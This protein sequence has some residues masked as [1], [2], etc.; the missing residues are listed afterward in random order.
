MRRQRELNP[1]HSPL[2]ELYWRRSRILNIWGVRSAVGNSDAPSL[3]MNLAK[4]RKRFAR[5]SSL[6]A[7]KGVD[8]AIGG[9]IYVAVVLA[10]LLYGSETWVWTSSILNT[11]WG[12]HHRAYWRLADKRPRRRQNRTYEYCSADEAMRICKLSSIQVYIARRR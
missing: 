9:R 7:R 11:I 4:A 2:M 3:L 5:I 12:F 10:V 6:I 8:L 1:E